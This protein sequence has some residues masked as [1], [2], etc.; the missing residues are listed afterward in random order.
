MSY[1]AR[2]VLVSWGLPSLL[3]FCVD[4]TSDRVYA[5]QQ[6]NERESAKQNEQKREFSTKVLSPASQTKS[7]AD[8]SQGA[9]ESQTS[10]PAA[11]DSPKVSGQQ[12]VFIKG[13]DGQFFPVPSLKLDQILEYLKQKQTAQVERSPEYAVSSV[14][15]TGNIKEDRAILEA[16]IVVLINEENHWIR[17]PLKLNESIFLK[18]GYVGAGESSP[19]GFNRTDGYLWWFR[20]KGTHELNLTLSISLKQQ[21]PSR[22]LQL[23]LPQTAVSNLQLSIPLPQISLEVP[24]GVAVSKKAISDDQTRVEM[25]G[26][27]DQL[28][29]SWQPIPDEKKVETVLQA[30]TLLTTDFTSDSVLLNANQSIKALTG[31]F[32]SVQVK[33]PETFR[34]LDVK[35]E[36]YKSHQVAKGNLVDIQLIEPTVGP[37]ELQWTLETDF[38]EQSGRFLIDGFDV[39]RAKRQTGLID[40]QMLDGYRIFRTE[41]QNRFVYQIKANQKDL[42]SSYRFLKQPFQLPLNIE[43]VKPYFSAKP[44]YLVQMFGNRAEL[45]AR[46]QINVFQGALDQVSFNWPHRKEEGW[47]LELMQEPSLTEAIE[48][49]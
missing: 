29:L 41:G 43:R 19:G 30:E 11:E 16:R 8:S 15:L 37:I 6:S 32:Q 40:I 23:V 21:L 45:E 4:R 27:G 44:F 49:D 24:S 7:T 28:D 42:D 12:E 18:T 39:S 13:A 5:Q 35:C 22:R 33:L 34:L 25:F 14:S 17:V 36:G 31:S 38:P 26:L 2:I 20:G 10:K 46:V 1:L 48:I 3:F 9:S 47:E